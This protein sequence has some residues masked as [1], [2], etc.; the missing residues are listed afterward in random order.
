MRV[1]DAWNEA[2][3]LALGVSW[4]ALEGQPAGKGQGDVD[5]H[6]GRAKTLQHSLRKTH[7]VSASFDLSSTFYAVR[8]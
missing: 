6:F 7:H 5:L 3:L 1:W 2:V 8:Q 4:S